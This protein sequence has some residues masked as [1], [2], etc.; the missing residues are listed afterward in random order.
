MKRAATLLAVLSIAIAA[1]G[2]GRTAG[3]EPLPT[4]EVITVQNVSR[5]ELLR[6]LEIPDYRK[7]AV[8][9]CSV[10]FGP[11]G[12]LLVA[13]CGESQVPVW[14]VQTGSIVRVLYETPQHIVAC[15]FSS[16]GRRLACGGFDNAI[17]LWDLSTGETTA[18]FGAHAGPVWE[19][20][21]S[22]DGQT[23]ASCSLS[24]DVRLW[25][26]STHTMIWSYQG[27]NSYLSVA[28]APS[29]KTIA[30]GGRWDG[31]SI[32]DATTGQL[33]AKPSGPSYAPV[34]DV[35]FTFSGDILAAGADD[36]AIYL[37]DALACRALGTLQGHR[38]YV[39][40]IAFNPDGTLLASGSHD[41]TIGIWDVAGQRLLKTLEGHAAQVLRVA[42]SPDGT[43]LAS[44]SWDGTVRLWGVRQE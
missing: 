19:L 16:D 27:A 10:A 5:L 23:L 35:A 28:F 21:F 20:A 36:R 40:G 43:L 44:T 3:A 4:L 41:K 29:G 11:D 34:G 6:T 14:D 13:A 15:A 18:G 8:S 26:I 42:F 38:G 1:G 33:Y 39:N 17:T 31:V 24:A 30:C 7:G 37:W 32:L 12:R 9:Q 25:D 22:P 2:A